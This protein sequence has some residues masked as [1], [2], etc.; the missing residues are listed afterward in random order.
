MLSSGTR[1][2][3]AGERIRRLILGQPLKHI[4]HMRLV[5]QGHRDRVHKPARVGAR[6]VMRQVHFANVLNAIPHHGERVGGAL[7]E[8]AALAAE[9]HEQHRVPVLIEKL[10]VHVGLCACAFDVPRARDDRVRALVVLSFTAPLQRHQE[11]NDLMQSKKEK[12][13]PSPATKAYSL[14]IT[15]TRSFSETKNLQTGI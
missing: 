13:V 8:V 12:I 4:E 14:N 1:A 5:Q 7:V 3:N 6:V 2:D 11:T 15:I 9:V 10:H